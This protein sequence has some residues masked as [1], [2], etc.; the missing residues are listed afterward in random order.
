MNDSEPDWDGKM[1]RDQRHKY[2]YDFD[3]GSDTAGAHVLRLAGSD[4]RVLEIGAGPGSVTRVLRDAG[5]CKVTA[6]EIDAA[7][8]E[9]LR[10][11]CERVYSVDLN[12]P[13]WGAALEAEPPFDVVVAAD[14]LEHLYDPLR[15][16]GTMKGL[17]GEHGC[18]IVS[19]PHI[20]HS[21]ALA[22][23]ANEDFEYR[24]WGL[25]DK[26]HVRFFGVRNVQALAE[27]AGLKILEAAFVVKAPEETEFAEQ[28]VRCPVA[29]RRALAANPFG[30]VYQVVFKA[31]P[32]TAQGNPIQLT[33]LPV[34]QPALHGGAR[35]RLAFKAWVRSHTSFETRMRIR[36][37]VA[38]FGVDI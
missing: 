19:L 8:I 29:L 23:M 21:A 24:D 35:T 11:Y 13:D 9:K 25:L 7:A 37:F 28:W 10:P 4:K 34:P 31:V 18:V 22:S 33:S 32:D 27:Q 30:M 14:V 12:D 15:S 36:R 3:V 5:N 6:I 1:T 16:L 20:A 38:R 17:L 26:T 2:E